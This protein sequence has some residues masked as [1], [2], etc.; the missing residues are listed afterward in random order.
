MIE[1]VRSGT[2]NPDEDENDN[3][4]RNAL[5]AHGYWQAYQSVRKSI[6]KA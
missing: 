4:H 5:A 6:D 3:E 2:W 1:R